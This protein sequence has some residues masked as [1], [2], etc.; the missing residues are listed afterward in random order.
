MTCDS[1]VL[2]ADSCNICSAVPF[3]LDDVFFASLRDLLMLSPS[4]RNVT[5]T[6]D[7]SHNVEGGRRVCHVLEEMR[8]CLLA[9]LLSFPFP[10]LSEWLFSSVFFS[11]FYTSFLF[12]PF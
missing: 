5:S 8:G 12:Y 7:V 4:S 1:C 11:I 2:L 10:S 3:L 9:G 6:V